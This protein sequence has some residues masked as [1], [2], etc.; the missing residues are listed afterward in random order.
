MSILTS[1]PMDHCRSNVFH[2]QHVPPFSQQVCISPFRSMAISPRDFTGR[3]RDCFAK[4]S[5]EANS[6][7][8]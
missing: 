6:E 2:V 7:C 8:G 4:I 1:C 3:E 5:A